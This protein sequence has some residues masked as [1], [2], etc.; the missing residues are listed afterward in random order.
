MYIK[1]QSIDIVV[2]SHAFPLVTA[3]SV[4]ITSN[5]PSQKLTAT[6]FHLGDIGP[7]PQATTLFLAATHH[8]RHAREV[9]LSLM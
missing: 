2:A 3:R 8:E 1:R 4:S 9:L 7:S 5:I 6:P